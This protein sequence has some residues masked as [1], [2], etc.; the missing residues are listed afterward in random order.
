V[1]DFV[2]RFAAVAGERGETPAVIAGGAP[3]ISY[4]DLWRRARGIAG[5][6]AA[7]GAAR[8]GLRLHRSEG[9]LSAVLGTWAAGAAFAP[10]DLDTPAPRLAKMAARAGIDT[11]I[12]PAEVAAWAEKP[13]IDGVRG[14][15]PGDLAYLI[16]TSGSSGAPKAVEI[17]HRGLLCVLDQQ[18][19]AFAV[20]SRSRVGWMLAPWFDASISDFGTALLAGA[21]IVIE[22]P[23][24]LAPGLLERLGERRVSHIDLP[25]SLLGYLDPAA[26]PP[27]LETIVIGGEVCD[28]AAIRRWADRVR[29]INVYGPTEATICTSLIRCDRG[30]ERPLIGP[31]ID[32]IEYRVI[33]GELAIAGLGLAR[34]YAGDPA[35]TG[36]RFVGSGSDRIYRTG[37]A[38]AD[39]PGGLAFAGRRDRQVKV[40]G[41]LVAPE[42][43]EA[44]ARRRGAREVAVVA[45]RRG[46]RVQLFGFVAGGAA[47]EARAA[48]GDALP[49]WMVPARWEEIE[50]LPRTPSG[51]VDLAALAAR[52]GR[53]GGEPAAPLAAMSERER[54]I[55][56][57]WEAVTGV[58]PSD[59]ATRFSAAG[60]DS[61]AAVALLAAAETR[62]LELDAAAVSGD[63]TVREMAAAAGYRRSTAWLRRDAAWPAADAAVLAAARR[64]SPPPPGRRILVTGA[65]GFLGRALVPALLADSN[66]EVLGLAR[67]RSAWPPPGGQR[68]R[69]LRGDVAAPRFGL[70]PDRWRQLADEID[71]VVHLAAAVDLISGYE[72]LRPVNVEGAREAVRLA[73]TGRPKRLQLASSLVVFVAAGRRGRC[74]EADRL[75]ADET[76]AGG[77]AQS[78]WAAEIVVREAAL[79]GTQIIRLGLLVPPAAG[80]AFPETDWLR[81]VVRGIHRLG[82]V[83]RGAGLAVDM[84]PVDY[85]A[86]AMA[87]LV[88]APGGAA[89]YH[90]ANRRS[91]TIEDL[92]AAIERRAGPLQ[93]CP[94]EEWLAAADR[95]DGGAEP[96]VAAALLG[97]VRA[98]GEGERLARLRGFDL[99]A[100][101]GCRFDD[102]EAAAALAGSGLACPPPTA[103]L[104]DRYVGAI[105]S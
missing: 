90:L 75:E 53:G 6:L 37:D 40:G 9:F 48:V 72:A 2:E 85:A 74:L 95:A 1:S 93:R 88:R 54:A 46:G 89:T 5:V 45:A 102:R 19:E 101:T 47:A 86:G 22:D 50:A 33:D 84:T 11:W 70:E 98:A 41:R 28:P 103:A 18:I 83:P 91:A 30:W 79:P 3:V 63:A 87:A 92:V 21:A 34:G 96:E 13:A 60:G 97:L 71:A 77:Y 55:A 14:A 68:L 65:T 52:A 4:R 100:A 66:I 42:E 99:F 35:L 69:W 39:G 94:P 36:E 59:P 64:R 25:P 20:T 27:S 29:L 12:G 78:K 8:V 23:W 76:L 43:I 32:G 24:P 31:P 80:G 57:L 7:A 26:A 73:A 16:F 58:R 38:V 104:L 17:E 82:A 61:L 81:L 44:A 56:E 15:A 10:I 51:K 105:L 62:G 67:G 49:A